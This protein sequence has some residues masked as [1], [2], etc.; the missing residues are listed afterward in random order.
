MKLRYY[1]RGLGIGMVV[2]AL[3]MGIALKGEQPLSDAEIRLRAMELGMVDSDSRT[4]AGSQTS[5][6]AG[7]EPSEPAAAP[8]REPTPS[9]TATP[10]PE[11][12][13]EPV[14]VETPMP[15]ETP[16]SGSGTSASKPLPMVTLKPQIETPEPTDAASISTPESTQE[17]V[18]QSPESVTFVIQRGQ[19]S[20]GVAKALAE[21]GLI[22]DASAFDQ[23]L[24][25][26]GY[27]KRINSGTYEIPVDSTA[28]EIAKIITRSR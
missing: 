26:N 27:S 17:P 19:S 7:Q 25:S 14:P 4:L 21:A 15:V 22:E 12:T 23:Y 20:Y 24:E 11:P 9:P 18:P 1:L 2:T 6:G 16:S 5:Q 3:L 13:Q 10:S 8:T 28:E